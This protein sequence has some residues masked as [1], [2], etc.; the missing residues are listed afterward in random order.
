MEEAA[1]LPRTLANATSFEDAILFVD[2]GTNV[3]AG[4]LG[5]RCISITAGALGRHGATA[6]CHQI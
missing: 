6:G 4:R 2:G 5:S 3:F 1:D